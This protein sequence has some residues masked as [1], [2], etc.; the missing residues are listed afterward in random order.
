LLHNIST[1]L[2]YDYSNTKVCSFIVL[3]LAD[4]CRCRKTP[5][6][7]GCTGD[8]VKENDIFILKN[9]R[10]FQIENI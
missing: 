10:E 2:Q 6:K 3:L 5:Y 9:P 1:D 7:R 8:L 4:I